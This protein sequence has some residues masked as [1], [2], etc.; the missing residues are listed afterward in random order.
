MKSTSEQNLNKQGG[1]E[2]DP[3]NYDDEEAVK[4]EGARAVCEEKG[5]RYR[6][7]GLNLAQCVRCG[8]VVMHDLPHSA[9]NAD[10]GGR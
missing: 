7:L 4:I 5:H 9:F 2:D 3:V 6:D 1:R 8:D 10:N